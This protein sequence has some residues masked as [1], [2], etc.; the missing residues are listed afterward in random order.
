MWPPE[1]L[2]FLND[3]EENNDREWFKANRQ[4][5]DEY[6]LGP[7]RALAERLN[8]LGTP[9][10]FRPY[11]DTRFHPGPPIKENISVALGYGDSGGYYVELSLDGLFVAAGLYQPTTPQLERFRA[12]IA[13]DRRARIFERAVAEAAAAGLELAEPELKRAPRGYAADHPR[14][15]RLRLKRLTLHH[16]HALEPWLH[17]SLCDQ[18]I[19]AELDAARPFVEWVAATAG[20]PRAPATEPVQG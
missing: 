3:L 20:P 15:D 8:H 9:H 18:R 19:Q 11:R 13:D 7:A 6:L 4:R 14:L 2:E 5:Y 10:F 1:A 12:A 17:E 16:R